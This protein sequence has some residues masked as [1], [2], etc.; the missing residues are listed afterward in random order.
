MYGNIKGAVNVR[1][2][3]YVVYYAPF[4]IGRMA[5]EKLSVSNMSLS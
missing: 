1:T 4:H 3:V 5:G 2:P